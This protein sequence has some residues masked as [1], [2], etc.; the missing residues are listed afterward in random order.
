MTRPFS[1][2]WICSMSIP[3]GR[4]S[5][6]VPS[7][8]TSF[9]AMKQFSRGFSWKRLYHYLSIC[10]LTSEQ[11][12]PRVAMSHSAGGI[13]RTL[14]AVAGPEISPSGCL[15][16]T[17][18]LQIPPAEIWDLQLEGHNL[19]HTSDRSSN[20]ERSTWQDGL[21]HFLLLRSRKV[22]ARSDTALKL[23][24][25]GNDPHDGT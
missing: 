23:F 11:Y 15:P 3:S 14:W 7:I 17:I 18:P 6:E 4:E 12:A 20:R 21:Q 9:L 5:K 25:L 10:L 2:I 24:M 13:C 1:V 22:E 8:T 16:T 19:L